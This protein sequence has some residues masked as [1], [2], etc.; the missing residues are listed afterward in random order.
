MVP[1]AQ[2]PTV[3]RILTLKGV[4]IWD[5]PLLKLYMSF[6]WY[7]RK[8]HLD[9]KR[10]GICGYTIYCKHYNRNKLLE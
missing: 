9:V 1:Q 3:D 7:N 10:L 2:Q 6:R 5:P 4:P 8:V